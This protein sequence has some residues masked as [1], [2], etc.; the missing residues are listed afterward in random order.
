LI[1]PSHTRT[2]RHTRFGEESPDAR[3]TLVILL[4][5]KQ[6][7]DDAVP[8]RA[9]KKAR[10]ALD[11]RRSWRESNMSTPTHDDLSDLRGRDA[12]APLAPLPSWVPTWPDGGAN[13]ELARA[14]ESLWAKAPNP[15]DADGTGEY[16]LPWISIAAAAGAGGDGKDGKDATTLGPT[17]A[18][19][20]EARGMCERAAGK[21]AVGG[22]TSWIQLDP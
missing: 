16:D 22:C 21:A 2:E 10:P 17:A 20:L 11:G 5:E 18:A 4:L 3:V 13:P 8:R 7:E 19:L 12:S 9:R 15:P 14:I 6:S 1:I